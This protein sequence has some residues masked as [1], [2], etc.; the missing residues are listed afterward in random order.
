ME[1]Y[2]ISI[3]THQL[4]TLA[5][6]AI[7]F[8]SSFSNLAIWLSLISNLGLQ[9][10]LTLQLLLLLFSQKTQFRHNFS[11]VFQTTLLD[12]ISCFS[13]SLCLCNFVV[14]FSHVHVSGCVSCVFFTAVV[15]TLKLFFKL[16]GAPSN[17]FFSLIFSICHF[18]IVTAYNL[19]Y[20]VKLS[21][22]VVVCRHVRLRHALRNV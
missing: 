18:H 21:V 4:A 6:I 10:K 19:I 14:F 8:L 3:S 16:F 9:K 15:E 1:F 20:L 5:F 13:I 11:V 17:M 12:Y 2:N 22:S 7:Y